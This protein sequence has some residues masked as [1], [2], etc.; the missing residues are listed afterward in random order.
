MHFILMANKESTAKR[1]RQ[2]LMVPHS[3]LVIAYTMNI[4]PLT[5]KATIIGY[6]TY[7]KTSSYEDGYTSFK[8]CR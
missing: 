5:G 7:T 3:D 4:N 8:T 1:K 2:T 6:P